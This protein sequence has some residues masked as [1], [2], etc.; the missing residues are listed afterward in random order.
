MAAY[1]N[2]PFRQVYFLA[3][4][5]HTTKG[6]VLRTVKYGDTSIIASVYTELF[7][8]QSYI[9]NGVWSTS[10]KNGSRAMFF[11]PAVVL[12]MEVY[13]NN[14]KQLNRIKEYR[15]A[16]M[17]HN[18]FSDVIKNGIAQYMVEILHKCLKEPE[19]NADL[20]SFIEDCLKHLNSCNNAEMSN[21]PIYYSI[22][23]SNFFGFFPRIQCEVNKQSHPILFDMQE[24]IFTSRLPAH[25][26]YLEPYPAATLAELCT[27]Q[28]PAEL[29]NV[30]TNAEMRRKMLEA[31][32]TYYSLNIQDFGKLKTV[33]VL[34]EL[35]L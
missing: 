3:D 28:Q 10:K 8:L 9:I 35:M 21:F 6:I 19:S 30:R 29:S 27:V 5:I 1:S 18:I 32:E 2:F 20:F 11:Q 12:D 7:G 4:K 26:Y 33:P 23:L 16:C 17:L 13:H 34:R 31:L 22:H 14:F 15:L 25:R 24:G